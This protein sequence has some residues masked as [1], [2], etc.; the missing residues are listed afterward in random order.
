MTLDPSHDELGKEFGPPWVLNRRLWITQ[1]G[2]A[3]IIDHSS[4]GP[5]NDTFGTIEG[6]SFWRY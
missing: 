1:G 3:R 6:I 5:V 4:S 2:K